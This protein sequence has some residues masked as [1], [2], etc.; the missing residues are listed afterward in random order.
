MGFEFFAEYTLMDCP[1]YVSILHE[2]RDQRGNQMMV[3]HVQPDPK[4][5]NATVLRRMVSDWQAFRACTDAPMFAIEKYPDDRKWERF[6]K[7]MGF[8]FSSRV[9][10]ADGQSR[11]CFVSKKKNKNDDF[12]HQDKH[13]AGE[14]T[15]GST[16]AL[17][18]FCIPAGR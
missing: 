11:R 5:F 6:V 9:V 1:E 13:V 16:A 18:H 14:R 8:E 7:R 17:P 10:C 12:N 2:L 3:M 4:R 15:V